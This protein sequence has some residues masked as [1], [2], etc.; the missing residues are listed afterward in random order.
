MKHLLFIVIIIAGT[1]CSLFKHSGP[2]TKNINGMEFTS[3][4]L[5]NKLEVL[6]V[7]DTRFKKSSAAMAVMV[8]SMADPTNAPGMAHYLEHM[9]FL[10]TKSFPKP[11]EYATFMHTNGG[12]DNA[13]TADEITDFF[14][15]VDN[16]VM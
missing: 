14:F 4:T 10:G 8:G 3:L 16:S 7:H 5:P 2:P 12:W 1:S 6:L 9:L 11:A 13:Y 15:E